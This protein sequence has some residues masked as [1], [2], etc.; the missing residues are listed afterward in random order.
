[1]IE[2]STKVM[3][4]AGTRPEAIKVAPVIHCLLSRPDR[5]QTIIVATAQHRELLDQ[6]L[7]LLRLP[8]I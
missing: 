3:V 4:V 1:M 7:S 5:F 6:A 8:R 2:N